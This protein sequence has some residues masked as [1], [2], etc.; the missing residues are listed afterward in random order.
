M[1]KWAP[2]LLLASV[3]FGQ[4][5]SSL[6]GLVTD[7]AGAVVP[8]ASL[9]VMNAANG[10]KRSTTADSGGAYS[11]PQLTPGTYTLMVTAAGFRTLSVSG[12][13]VQ[14][15]SPAT[16]NFQLE[17][18]MAADAVTV[19]ADANP[20]NTQDASLGNNFS[21]KPILQLPFE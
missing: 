2:L 3:G 14:V 9:T 1:W 6:T 21:T 16:R 7:P 10:A 4:A 13:A 18:S 15:Q 12:I 17:L 5:L 19:T 11:F 8:G 20:V